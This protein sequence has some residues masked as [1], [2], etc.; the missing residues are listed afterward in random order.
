MQENNPLVT[1]H[2]IHF[3]GI[4]GIGISAIARMMLLEGKVVTGSDTTSSLVTEEL[5]KLGVRV[6]IGHRAENISTETD[7]IIYTI[8]APNDNP[9]LLEGKNRGIELITYP[10]ALG[11]LSQEKYTIA[12][13]G[14]HGKTTTTAMLAKVL[15]DAGKE[16][17]VIVGSFLKDQKSNFIAGTGPFVVEA[18]EYKKSFLNLS[19]KILI[20]TNI[21]LDHL[22]YY[23]DL[24]D[25]QSAFRELV[26]KVPTDGLVVTDVTHPNILRILANVKTKVIDYTKEEKNLNLS[27]P[28]AHNI[29]NAQ[30][31]ISVSSFYGLSKETT[32]ESLKNFSGTWRRFDYKGITKEGALVYDDYAHHPKEVEATILGFREKFPNKKLTI[33]FQPHLFSRT[34]HHL[35][36]FAEVLKKA[37]SVLVL[38]IYA[39]REKDPG[40][41]TSVD[42]VKKIGERSLFI[43]DKEESILALKNLEEGDVLVTMGAG[44]V[45][46]VGE[47]LLVESS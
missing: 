8:A 22:D 47:T 13:S 12:V 37:D 34:K 18:C 20:I 32:K 29:A 19:P 3:V 6:A 1:A 5:E 25:I 45:Y 16:P 41:I 23:K 42:L 44:D 27:L 14:T 10:E 43:K 30:A 28:G 40:D 35:D 36:D 33:L 11:L 17:T 24:E 7:L 21:D 15:V 39:A 46:T 9:E 2:Y 26:E 31:V 4:G 38:P